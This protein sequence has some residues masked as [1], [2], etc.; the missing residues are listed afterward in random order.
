MNFAES[1][2]IAF[3]KHTHKTVSDTENA[4]CKSQN[5]EYSGLL[6]MGYAVWH[7]FS[8]DRKQSQSNQENNEKWVL[9]IEHKWDVILVKRQKTR[10]QRLQDGELLNIRSLT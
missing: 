6:I 10:H 4:L 2:V 7:I 5:L 1:G 8:C 9:K 3:D